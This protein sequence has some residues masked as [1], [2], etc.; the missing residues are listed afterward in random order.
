MLMKK[1]TFGLSLI[2]MLFSCTTVAQEETNIVKLNSE[3]FEK[4]VQNNSNTIILDV[5]T[6][7][8]FDEGHIP[9]SINI[10]Y[11]DSDFISQM[12]TLDTTKTLLIY[13]RSGN[14]SSKAITLIEDSGFD[15]I[16]ELEG[17]YLAWSK[18]NE[19]NMN[20]K[21]HISGSKPVL[22]DFYAD[23]CG[24]CQQM[25]PILKRLKEN[26]GEKATILKI[27]NDK[28]RELALQYN[29]RS[30]P[31]LMVMKEGEVLWKQAGVLNEQ[32]LETIL[33]Q[34]YQYA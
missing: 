9:G 33:Q 3:Q 31:T 7:E 23:W 15:E 5:R 1:I 30:I 11:F 32:Q 24:P 10:N 4:K 25:K 22:V 29:I 19:N 6:V 26:I 8:E 12:E 27:D 34:Y 20:F 17:G 28:N 2:T 16:Y 13:C 14:R 21:E 18:N